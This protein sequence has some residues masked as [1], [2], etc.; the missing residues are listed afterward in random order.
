MFGAG[1]SG[2]SHT[3]SSQGSFF[4]VIFHIVDL[5]YLIQKERVYFITFIGT[6]YQNIVAERARLFKVSYSRS[7]HAIELLLFLLSHNFA[8]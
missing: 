7:F 2:S 8:P 6:F 3:G 4:C 5:E 1:G